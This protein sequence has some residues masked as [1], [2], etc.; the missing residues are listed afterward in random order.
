MKEEKKEREGGFTEVE[1]RED[2]SVVGSRP[3]SSSQ[4]FFPIHRRQEI[5]IKLVRPSF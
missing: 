1:G 3:C 5:K 4:H 2:G